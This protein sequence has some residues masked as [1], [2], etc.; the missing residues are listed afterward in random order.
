MT[1]TAILFVC[2]GNICRSPAAEGVLRHL[3]AQDPQ[4]AGIHIESCGLGDWHIGQLPDLR[5]REVAKTRGL[6]LSSRAQRFRPSFFER[7]DYILAA[8][9]DV[10]N[11][12]YQFARTSEQ[13]TI[14]HLMTAFATNFKDEDVPDPYYSG[15]AGF[16]LVLDM[17]EESCTGLLDHLRDLTKN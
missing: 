3:A 8:D 1:M 9:R 13:K 11:D 14:I 10:L 7:F 5:M 12:L 15:D 4:F 17:L 6:T 16:E 2:L